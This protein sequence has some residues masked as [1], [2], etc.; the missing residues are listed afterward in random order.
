MIHGRTSNPYD[1]NRI[2][3]GSSGGE[4][5]NQAAAGAAFGIGSDIGGSIRIPSFFNGVFGHKPSKA[6]ISNIGQYPV[7]VSDVQRNMLG[8][9]P[10]CR[11][12]EDLLPIFKVILKKEVRDQLKLDEKID[13]KKIKFYYQQTNMGIPFVSPVQREIKDLF[14]KIVLHL[15]TALK[16]KAQEVKLEKFRKS[17]IIWLADM[18]YGNGPTFEE[19]L[20]NLEGK[21][22]TPLEIL[23]WCVGMSNH[24]FV[25]LL[26]A[27]VERFSIKPNTPKYDYIM[28]QKKLLI[29]EIMDLLGDDGVFIYPTHPTAA[30]YHNESIFKAMN[31]TYTG[32][33]NSLGFPSTHCPMGLNS[34]GLP[35]GLQVV[36]NVNNDRLCLA[37]AMEL[38]KAFGGWVPPQVVS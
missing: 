25:A 12:A 28:D 15:G 17:S 3:G 22:N 5:C 31:F 8:I 20:C 23:K 1:T 11:R 26:T 6:I 10:I 32:I 21:I 13:V 2:V 18:N 34:E 4:A 7:P 14:G 29:E 9:G 37:V 19:Q 24:T 16:I 33:I 36:S 38:E 27:V 35:I 30:L